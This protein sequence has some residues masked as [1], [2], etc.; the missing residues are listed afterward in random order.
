MSILPPKAKCV[1]TYGSD[2][3]DGVRTDSM[4]AQQVME[5]YKTLCRPEDNLDLIIMPTLEYLT[6][7]YGDNGYCKATCSKLIILNAVKINY[8]KVLNLK[9]L[10]K[11]FQLTPEIMDTTKA[12]M[13]DPV[14]RDILDLVAARSAKPRKEMIRKIDLTNEQKMKKL[15]EE[16][17]QKRIEEEKARLQSIEQEEKKEPIG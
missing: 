15:K 10:G 1:F 17:P 11:K 9:I 16:A 5:C 3:G 14:E 2:V 12:F 13:D 8:H 6:L 4:V 7:Q